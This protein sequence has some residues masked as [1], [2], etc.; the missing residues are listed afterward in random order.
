MACESFFFVGSTWY[1]LS[2][3]REQ[4]LQSFTRSLACSPLFPQYEPVQFQTV[5][6]RVGPVG[7]R[8]TDNRSSQCNI[9]VHFDSSSVF[10]R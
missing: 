4:T 7:Y 1:L 3:S 2:P 10:A 8:L 6:A 5:Q 9:T